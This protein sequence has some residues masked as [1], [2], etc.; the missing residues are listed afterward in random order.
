MPAVSGIYILFCLLVIL[1]SADRI[2]AVLRAVFSAAFEPGSAVE[3][4]E[5]T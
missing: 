5:A 4:L 2:P 1:S 3:A